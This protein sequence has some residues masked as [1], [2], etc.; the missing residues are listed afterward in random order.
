[1]QSTSKSKHKNTKSSVNNTNENESKKSE[2]INDKKQ[3]IKSD[4]NNIAISKNEDYSY[5]GL[6]SLMLNS[7]LSESS[8][9]EEDTV[10]YPQLHYP[11]VNQQEKEKEFVSGFQLDSKNSSCLV[12]FEP[13]EEDQPLL[14]MPCKHINHLSCSM[15][16]IQKIN[17]DSL[18]S[19][20][21]CKYCSSVNN[22]NGN[23]NN[24]SDNNNNMYF[25]KKVYDGNDNENN[26]NNKQVLTEEE[27]EELEKMMIE[28]HKTLSIDHG[29]DSSI[30]TKHKRKDKINN[31]ENILESNNGSDNDSNSDESEDE[32]DELKIDLS[33]INLEDLM[34][35]ETQ[36]YIIDK[37]KIQNLLVGKGLIQKKILSIKTDLPDF[38][39]RYIQENDITLSD[40]IKYNFTLDDIFYGLQLDNI[41]DLCE[42][43]KIKK[44]HFEYFSFIEFIELY[45]ITYKKLEGI[46]SIDL[47]WLLHKTEF[48]V[49]VLIALELDF[50]TLVEDFYFSK[51]FVFQLSENWKLNDYIKLNINY[52]CLRLLEMNVNDFITLDWNIATLY[53]HLQP[54]SNFQM[55]QLKI[56]HDLIEMA[57][58]NTKNGNKKKV[59]TKKKPN[60]LDY[61]NKMP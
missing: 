56:T 9:K 38:D 42:Y 49:D 7:S 41:I 16:Y 43:L 35:N 18:S 57:N 26:N 60:Q 30:S 40:L 51:K 11:E 32:E 33:N 13:L 19:V 44:K 15:E 31:V 52:K 58:T 53:S 8:K 2:V 27:E 50:T 6:Y 10:A 14:S 12:C 22:N 45:D 37:K 39:L 36:T 29:N 28:Q 5:K 23:S 20:I 1:M 17:N 54:L 3:N 61:K 59:T 48:R 25:Q 34:A 21:E 4:N 47:Q 55:K 46:L 24:N